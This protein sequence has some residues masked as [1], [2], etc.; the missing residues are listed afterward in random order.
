MK[1]T[2]C[3]VVFVMLLFCAGQAAVLKSSDGQG[4]RNFMVW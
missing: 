3:L 1:T 4:E 2:M